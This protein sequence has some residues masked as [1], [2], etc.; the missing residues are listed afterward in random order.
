MNNYVRDRSRFGGDRHHI[1]TRS[2]ESHQHFGAAIQFL[3]NTVPFIGSIL[4]PLAGTLT[5]TLI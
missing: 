2:R 3:V 1:L 4:A 5:A